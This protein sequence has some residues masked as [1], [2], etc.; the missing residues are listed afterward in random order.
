M[1]GCVLTPEL[2]EL[3]RDIARDFEEHPERWAP[4]DRPPPA[5]SIQSMRRLI[6]LLE[7][8]RDAEAIMEMQ[9]F[10]RLC[11]VARGETV[12]DFPSRP[13]RP[14]PSPADLPPAA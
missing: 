9:R 1:T 7:Q 3:R 13:R 8:R 11:R 2:E 10:V 12:V 4:H 6:R 14:I 5:G